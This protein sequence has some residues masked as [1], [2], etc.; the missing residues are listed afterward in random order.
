[1]IKKILKNINTSNEEK[2]DNFS[3]SQNIINL[4]E[5]II[6]NENDYWKYVNILDELTTLCYEDPV[7]FRKFLFSKNEQKTKENKLIIDKIIDRIL[8]VLEKYEDSR[9]TFIYA[10]SKLIFI[11]DYN[12]NINIL[13]IL[14]NLALNDEYKIAI[15]SAL[16]E[17]VTS[18]I[19]NSSEVNT[20]LCM[21]VTP[22][23]M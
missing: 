4:I 10:I 14:C 9:N 5:E 3:H 18:T 23:S 17:I 6:K 2:D 8:I 21:C 11:N 22:F 1:M 19:L 20:Y 15:C 7:D 12:F 16:E 13:T